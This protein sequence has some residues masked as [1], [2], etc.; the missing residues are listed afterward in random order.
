MGSGRKAE[1]L[2]E[3]LSFREIAE[4]YGI[5]EATLRARYRPGCTV[6]ELVS[7]TFRKKTQKNALSVKGMTLSEIARRTGLSY[8]TLYW[9]YRSGFTS[10]DELTAQR[11][12]LRGAKKKNGGKA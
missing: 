4:K 5:R 11:Y 10:Y 3:G 2:I 6:Q 8:N 1:I 12:V 9:R 7:F